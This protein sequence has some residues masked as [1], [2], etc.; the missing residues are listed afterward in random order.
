MSKRVH[1]TLQD[2]QYE[3]WM[4]EAKKRDISIHD[5]I[6]HAVKVYITMLEVQKAR[7]QKK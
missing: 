1:L 2:E 5:F 7:K 4:K 3:I 6:K